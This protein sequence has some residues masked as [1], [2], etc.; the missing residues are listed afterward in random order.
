M[1]K[2][3]RKMISNPATEPIPNRMVLPTTV[4]APSCVR[5]APELQWALLSR[6]DPLKPGV[7]APPQAAVS[8][9]SQA[10]PCCQG[11]MSE[12]GCAD[13]GCECGGGGGIPRV[14]C[15]LPESV[16]KWGTPILVRQFGKLSLIVKRIP[17]YWF[18]FRKENNKR[19]CGF[20]AILTEM[21]C[22]RA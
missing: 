17:K 2:T 13:T 6:E 11:A 10:L 21:L 20:M 1:E 7:L 8:G 19:N 12:N 16:S 22:G 4:H 14:V 15:H 5:A 3:N 18:L 9:A